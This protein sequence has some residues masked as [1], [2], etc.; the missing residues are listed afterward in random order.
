MDS[1]QK[2]IP[3]KIEK[4]DTSVHS[5]ISTQSKV[6]SKSRTSK[7]SNSN[8]SY[9]SRDKVGVFNFEITRQSSTSAM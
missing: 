1:K 2:S 4:D 8:V 3:Q 9:I 7:I 5:K 6:S